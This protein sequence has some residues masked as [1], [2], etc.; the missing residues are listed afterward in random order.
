MRVRRTARGAEF[1]RFKDANNAWT[2]LQA[3]TTGA[4]LWFGLDEPKSIVDNDHRLHV[5][6]DTKTIKALLIHLHSYIQREALDPAIDAPEP[7]YDVK[8]STK[9]RLRELKNKEDDMR[10]TQRAARLKIQKEFALTVYKE[11]IE[12]FMKRYNVKIFYVNGVVYFTNAKGEDWDGFS[13]RSVERLFNSI[14][15]M[16]NGFKPFE[17]QHKWLTAYWV[18]SE[19]GPKEG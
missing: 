1:I 4:S 12:P 19:V 13:H 2:T 17:T 18:V 11:L 6:L 15:D 7:L 5:L 3:A 8:T 14:D 10:K 9:D 16:C